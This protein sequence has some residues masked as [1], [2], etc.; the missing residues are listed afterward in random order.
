MDGAEGDVPV[1][2]VWQCRA[3]MAASPHPRACACC[4]SQ[5]EA[6]EGDGDGGDSGRAGG[7]GGRVGSTLIRE[8]ARPETGWAESSQ[9]AARRNF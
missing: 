9:A 2:T 3:S 7:E 4:A 1:Q 5:R 8:V 6:G